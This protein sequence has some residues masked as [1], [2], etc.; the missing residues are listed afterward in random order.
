M[1]FLQ[2]TTIVVQQAFRN[3]NGATPEIRG[4]LP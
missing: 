1:R 3:M 2:R 4:R